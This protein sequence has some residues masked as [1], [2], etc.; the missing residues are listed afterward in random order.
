MCPPFEV[1]AY[2]RLLPFPGNGNL[3]FILAGAQKKLNFFSY[4][5]DVPMTSSCHPSLRPC[6]H[7]ADDV[8]VREGPTCHTHT[9]PEFQISDSASGTTP[10]RMFSI[11]HAAAALNCIRVITAG[12]LLLLV[13]IGDLDPGHF[14]VTARCRVRDYRLPSKRT[15]AFCLHPIIEGRR[16]VSFQARIQKK[17]KVLEPSN[18][19]SCSAQD[20]A[21]VVWRPTLRFTRTHRAT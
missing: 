20:E 14:L 13:R 17:K 10:P 1:P 2:Q 7:C 15:A 18:V 6:V 21:L 8:I 11:Q 9:H 5:S 19:V 16:P 3:V 12:T 4:Q